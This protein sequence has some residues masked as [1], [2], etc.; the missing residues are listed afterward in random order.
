M[1]G[2]SRRGRLFVLS[3]PSGVGKDTV[4]AELLRIRPEL[5]RPPAFTT[6]GQR[7]GEVAGRDYWFVDEETF[8]AMARGGQFL[9][10]ALVHGHRYGT[11]REAV[12]ELLGSGRDVVLKPDVQGA[13]QLRDAGLEATFIF[14]AP[15]DPGVL[16]ERL[17]RRGTESP[18]E[19]SMR[20]RDQPRELAAAAS[21]DH[22][23]VND[24][25]ERAAREIADLVA[26]VR[27]GVTE[28]S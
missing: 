7:P 1:P 10:T 28:P 9:E 22:R 4:L 6:R 26:G 23:V 20:L 16:V 14:L 27:P 19:I 25:V 24:E 21:F 11:P 5:G 3:G 12:E 15:P 8:A 18:E 2:Q 17:R 13:A